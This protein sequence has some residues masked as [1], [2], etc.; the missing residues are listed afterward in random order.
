M[1]VDHLGLEPTMK[2]PFNLLQ[3]YTLTTAKH[4][5]FSV[6][7]STIWCS[8]LPAMI[9]CVH[10]MHATSVKLTLGSFLFWVP[11]QFCGKVFI[12]TPACFATNTIV[13]FCLA[14]LE[15]TLCIILVRQLPAYVGGC[16]YRFL[17]L[18][19]LSAGCCKLSGNSFSHRLFL[20]FLPGSLH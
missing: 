16:L 6:H 20:S 2:V 19:K 12:L 14:V 7:Q 11:V 13:A 1:Y 18:Q 10:F 15:E 17:L 4:S 8:M 9:C 3:T 5:D